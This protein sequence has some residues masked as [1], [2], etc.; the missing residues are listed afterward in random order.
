LLEL[1]FQRLG[2]HARDDRSRVDE[3]T[4]LDQYFA[5]ASGRLGGDVDG[6]GLDPPVAGDE[7]GGQGGGPRALPG[8]DSCSEGERGNGQ[9][10]DQAPCGGTHELIVLM[11]L[12]SL[13]GVERR[14]AVDASTRLSSTVGARL[15]FTSAGLPGGSP[16]LGSRAV[17]VPPAV[18]GQ[19]LQGARGVNMDHRVEAS[20]KGRMRVMVVAFGGRQ[21][22]H[23]DAAIE[24]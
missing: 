15:D 5:D 21:V 6:G 2:I 16:T 22:G 3:V 4:F 7:A 12:P 17:S 1:G 19:G 24:A 13:A 18:S 9:E 10:E 8:M 23:A 20:G 14:P 11:D